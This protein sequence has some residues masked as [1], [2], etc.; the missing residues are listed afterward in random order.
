MR[1]DSAST[2][3]GRTNPVAS[4]NDNNLQS[5]HNNKPTCEYLVTKVSIDNVLL[6][7]YISTQPIQETFYNCRKV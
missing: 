6:Y 5:S 4:P 3:F 2:I 7:N 1:S